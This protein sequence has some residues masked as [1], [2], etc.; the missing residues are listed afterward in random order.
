M[1]ADVLL[2]M[3]LLLVIMLT[4][5]GK[6][7]GRLLFIAGIIV[8]GICLLSALALGDSFSV[9][10]QIGTFCCWCAS[11][12]VRKYAVELHQAS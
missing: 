2:T 5:L 9:I 7:P 11:L 4:L 8:S 10:M 3:A 1:V 6:V 12:R